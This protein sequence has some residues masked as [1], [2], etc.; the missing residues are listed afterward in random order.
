MCE[1]AVSR[2]R[3]D[4]TISGITLLNRWHVVIGLATHLMFSAVA[5]AQVPMTGV[6]SNPV[7][8]TNGMIITGFRDA[9]LIDQEGNIAVIA[10]VLS[11]GNQV[12]AVILRAKQSAPLSSPIFSTP[13]LFVMAVQNHT[14]SGLTD[15]ATIKDLQTMNL[16][17]GRVGVLATLQ[18][19]NV[20]T[21]SDAAIL[22][23]NLTGMTLR[24]R[25][26]DSDGIGGTLK[27]FTPPSFGQSGRMVFGAKLVATEAEAN[28]ILQEPAFAVNMCCTTVRVA[29]GSQAPGI[30]TFAQFHSFG[31]LSEPILVSSTNLLRFRGTLKQNAVPN[32]SE[33]IWSELLNLIPPFRLR[34]RTGHIETPPIGP[35]LDVGHLEL[36]SANTK[37]DLICAVRSTESTGGVPHDAALMRLA[38]NGIQM[39]LARQNQAATG[40]SDSA[41]FD[42]SLP[43]PFTSGVN[44]NPQIRAAVNEFGSTAFVCFLKGGPSVPP[45]CCTGTNDCGLWVAN[46]SGVVSLIARAGDTHSAL[47]AGA[48]MTSRFHLIGINSAETVVF[49]TGWNSVNGSGMALWCWQPFGGIRLICRTGAQSPL[50]PSGFSTTGIAV[51]AGVNPS[52]GDDGRPL[53]LNDQGSLCFRIDDVSTVTGLHVSSVVTANLSQ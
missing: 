31:D 45:F 2:G 25:E 7:A 19:A 5:Y 22:A 38:A 15:G 14:V 9:P 12:D 44:L 8:T 28:E 10:K 51:G 26:G 52:G 1:L 47:P 23:T 34:D 16:R 50:H 29:N 43:V 3:M 11:S 40:V 6:I 53:V 37:G 18:G 48:T 27:G 35:T 41:T 36:L 30:Q 46:P 20:T 42:L 39:M 17:N 32:G 33:G 49:T 13:Q 4:G 24:V 21:N